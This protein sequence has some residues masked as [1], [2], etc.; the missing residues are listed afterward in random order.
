MLWVKSVTHF[1]TEGQNFPFRCLDWG[2]YVSPCIYDVATPLAKPGHHPIPEPSSFLIHYRPIDFTSN[3]MFMI[4]F[5][6]VF[7]SKFLQAVQ[8]PGLLC[9]CSVLVQ[10][11][12]V[13]N[14][15]LETILLLRFQVISLKSYKGPS[16]E[17]H[18]AASTGIN[19]CG[20]DLQHKSADID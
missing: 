5:R 6:N 17:L 3:S 11:N 7:Y 16:L 10:L 4:L 2:F 15:F 13:V 9:C 20:P 1:L 19:S 8:T 14:Y 18:S 12:I